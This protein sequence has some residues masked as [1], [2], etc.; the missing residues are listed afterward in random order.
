MDSK[1]EEFKSEISDFYGDTKQTKD[2]YKIQLMQVL[3][4]NGFNSFEDAKRFYP[5][6]SSKSD[7]NIYLSEYNGPSTMYR[8]ML[9]AFE[10]DKY[11]VFC[12][13]LKTYEMVICELQ[14]IG[15][16]QLCIITDFFLTKIC[17]DQTG[18]QNRYILPILELNGRVDHI[19]DHDL[20]RNPN[21]NFVPILM[22]TVMNNNI[23][24]LKIIIENSDYKLHWWNPSG[25]NQTY[26]N[27]TVYD[28]CVLNNKIDCF[29]LLCEHKFK[30]HHMR[31]YNI[32]Q[33]KVN[34]DI[35][36]IY[37]DPLQGDLIESVIRNH[38]YDNYELFVDCLV[39]YDMK[40]TVFLYDCVHS[41]I[42]QLNIF[43][44]LVIQHLLIYIIMSK[45]PI[46]DTCDY[47]ENYIY[48]FP[49]RYNYLKNIIYNMKNEIEHTILLTKNS[50]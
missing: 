9:Q 26:I 32:P 23:D 36:Q 19:D 17:S 11:D 25:F 4:N 8:Y 15:A 39:S 38:H 41:I 40:D 12:S 50:T 3:Q 47:N 27:H 44:L 48:T 37:T 10:E 5:F 24:A 33:T 2:E 7:D 6:L 1:C 13:L 46:K 42:S 30:T 22:L 18:S 35:L 20:E 28:S 43:P 29:K 31:S 49:Y 16:D 21:S 34:E 45:K 14:E